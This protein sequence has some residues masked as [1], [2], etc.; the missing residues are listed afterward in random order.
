ME[1]RKDDEKKS[2][3]Q[4][5]KLEDRIAPC[6]CGCCGSLVTTGDILS[7]NQIAVGNIGFV[8]QVS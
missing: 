4:I 7:S 6:G 1:T 8:K 3:F 2:R 5:V